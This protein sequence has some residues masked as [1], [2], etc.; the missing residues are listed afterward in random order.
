MKQTI[1]CFFIMTI[2]LTAGAP[3]LYHDDL[4]QVPPAPAINDR[5]E[6]AKP[7]YQGPPPT[8]EEVNARHKVL[9]ERLART[10]NLFYVLEAK[11]IESDLKY[12]QLT[13]KSD[14]EKVKKKGILESLETLNKYDI[15][16][17][18]ICV[19]VRCR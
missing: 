16:I 8:A 4:K 14:A 18:W 1:F 15:I 2:C 19:V 10:A 5:P 12:D 13:K 7:G 9:T 11:Q 6:W 3:Y 17:N